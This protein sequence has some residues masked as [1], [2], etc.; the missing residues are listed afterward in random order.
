MSKERGKRRKKKKSFTRDYI[1]YHFIFGSIT[2]CSLQQSAT[3]ILKT[4]ANTLLHSHSHASSHTHKL[5]NTVLARWWGRGREGCTE[6]QTGQTRVLNT[7]FPNPLRKQSADLS[8]GSVVPGR[9]DG[10]RLP[11]L[12]QGSRFGERGRVGEKPVSRGGSC[13]TE[14]EEKEMKNGMYRK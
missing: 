10:H 14:E 1:Y 13:P 11:A 2:P 8:G 3:F 7:Q 4:V 9:R 6:S 12:T 5:T